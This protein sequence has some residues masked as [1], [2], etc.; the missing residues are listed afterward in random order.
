MLSRR[1]SSS[2]RWRRHGGWSTAP[3]D[4]HRATRCSAPSTSSGATGRRRSRV[5]ARRRRSRPDDPAVLN[6][7]GL[8]LRESGDAAASAEV[9]ARGDTAASGLR[10]SR[11]NNLGLA[12]LA[13]D[14]VPARSRLPRRGALEAGLREAAAQP[15][16]RARA[17]PGARP[18]VS[19]SCARPSASTRST[20]EAWNSLGA[21]P[22]SGRPLGDAE[23]AFER[24][25]HIRPRHPKALLNR[26][27]LHADLNGPTTRA[28]AAI[29][30]RWRSSPAT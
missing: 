30:T 13:T 15:R 5:I 26:A 16:Q 3:R 2:W 20:P 28:R 17:V 25:L 21:G 1:D 6:N 10:G 9:A 22:P 19:P 27:H 14:D 4:T 24:A 8:A 23:A 11:L 29:A 18:P 7:L 12:L